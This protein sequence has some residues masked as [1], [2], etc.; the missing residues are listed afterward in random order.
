MYISSPCMDSVQATLKGK[1]KE[2]YFGVLMSEAQVHKWSQHKHKTTK[3]QVI[4]SQQQK[5]QD[6]K[7]CLD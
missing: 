5:S 1:G 4:K 6:K 2:R 7:E 3:T